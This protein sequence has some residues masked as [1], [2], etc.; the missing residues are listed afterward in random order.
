M[1]SLAKIDKTSVLNMKLINL[2]FLGL[3]LFSC[4]QEQPIKEEV[5]L[6]PF[7]LQDISAEKKIEIA[8]STEYL[9]KLNFSDSSIIFIQEYYSQ[10]NYSPRWIN[11]STVNLIG[12]ELSKTFSKPY[13]F[14][15]PTKR[16]QSSNGENYIQTEI[17][18][19]HNLAR[20]L[21][22]LET[23]IINYDSLE[24][25]PKNL[26]SIEKMNDFVLDI[27]KN[28]SQ[29]FLSIGP[30]DSTFLALAK[31]LTK[32]LEKYPMDTST[33]NIESIKYDTLF[34]FEKT[35]V[36]LVSKGYLPSD[37]SDS[38][39]ILA[40]L[41]QFQFDNGL[42]EDGVIGKYTSKALNESTYHK[43]ERILLAMDKVRARRPRP[44]KY[45]YINIPEYKLRLYINDSLKSEHN[46][47]VGKIGNE[48][49][50]LTSKLRKI[51][52][53]PFWNLPYSI[54]SKEILPH[55]KRNV[56]YMDKH[57]YKLIKNG[58]IIDPSTVDWSKVRQN[59]FRYKIRQDP[60]PKNA[61]GI[62]KFDFYNIHSVYFHDTPSKSLFGADVR[63]YSHGCMR[64]QNPIDLAKVI[65]DRDEVRNKFNVMTSDS[66]DTL[67]SRGENYEI[68][69]LKPIPIYIEYL[70]ITSKGTQMK[71][72][73]D[74]YG[75]DEEY[76]KIMR[77]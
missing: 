70:S 56:S 19:T 76:L 54:S 3:L 71:M 73:I 59:S 10:R 61:L 13:S 32:I 26:I 21:S 63:A 45:I 28:Q 34:A 65:L 27:T 41:K 9:Q 22:D 66:L 55:L 15:I 8:L 58:E 33:F 52:V 51:V 35:R 12:S 23:G 69:L 4:K 17:L 1:R 14:G 74:V 42:K 30:K 39:E 36:A 43:I 40:S 7:E 68:K 48:T 24:Q 29:Q 62:I 64:T 53:Y 31:G 5:I 49:P 75:R 60:G 20:V 50:E 11:D 72:F 6:L 46:V 57:N 77:E 38:M 16:I 37:V 2:I 67:F 25:K 44:D 47:V 18:L